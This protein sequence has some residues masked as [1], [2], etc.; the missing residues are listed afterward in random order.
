MAEAKF[1]WYLLTPI[2]TYLAVVICELF[3]SLQYL[4]ITVVVVSVVKH[5]VQPCVFRLGA[6]LPEQGNH[7]IFTIYTYRKVVGHLQEI[8]L[9]H[10]E[11]I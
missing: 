11:I 9:L 5:R 6:K 1:Y 3:V 10:K 4:R 7:I 2:R 8:G